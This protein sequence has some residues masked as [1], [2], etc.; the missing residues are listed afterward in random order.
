ME[1]TNESSY[2][3]ITPF[4]PQEICHAPIWW[5]VK[6]PAG[7]NYFA[8]QLWDCCVM[9]VALAGTSC[10]RECNWVLVTQASLGRLIHDKIKD[11]RDFICTQLC[12]HQHETVK[13]PMGRRGGKV[14]YNWEKENCRSELQNW[15]GMG[16]KRENFT[17]W[18]SVLYLFLLATECLPAGDSSPRYYRE[19]KPGKK[20]MYC[21]SPHP[22]NFVIN[23]SDSY[24][25][26]CYSCH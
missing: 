22:I 11:N 19:V 8:I 2:K 12:T 24:R 1:F 25:R 16:E 21:F 6:F 20:N 15:E 14:F 17:G 10:P 7:V 4:K 9:T 13:I 18:T 26:A 5:F 3:Q 23:K